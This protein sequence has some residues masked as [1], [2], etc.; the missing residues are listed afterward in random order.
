MN[1]KTIGVFIALVVA[2][3]L[4]AR[5]Q[6]ATALRINEVLVVNDSNYMDDYGVHS[7]WIEIFNTSYASVD[8]K[9]C[10]LTN[11]KNNPTKYPIPKGDVLTLIKPRQHALFWADNMPSRGTFHLNFSLNPTKENYI[12]LYDSNG[13]T[14]IDEVTVPAGLKPDQSY[15]R[16]D[17]G[18]DKW[19]IKGGEAGGYVTPSTNNKTLDKNVKIENFKEHDPDGISM[20]IIAMGVVFCGLLVLFLA[21]KL[22]GNIAVRL[23][24]RNAMKAH[25]ITD[26]DEAKEKQLGTS[27]GEEFAAISMAMHEYLSDV[28]DIE[29]MII[30][31]NKVKRTYSPWSSKIY[32]LRQL[33]QR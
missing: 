21:F 23:S 4:N 29:N 11:D 6:S 18:H 32:N 13:K 12:A 33:P 15:A 22:V 17:D 20:T 1:K 25:G 9:G 16:E 2:F 14:L 26:K 3:G 5:A 10:Y 19:V 27:T 7:A 24:K 8:L 28:H 31:I 30:T